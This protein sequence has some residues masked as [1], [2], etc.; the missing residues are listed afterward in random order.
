MPRHNSAPPLHFWGSRV[1][2][3]SFGGDHATVDSEEEEEEEEIVGVREEA[4]EGRVFVAPER[5]AIKG[6]LRNRARM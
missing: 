6:I 3:A 5:A 2:L 4:E 1:R